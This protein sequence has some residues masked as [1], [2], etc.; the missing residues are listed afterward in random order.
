MVAFGKQGQQTVVGTHKAISLKLCAAQHIARD[1]AITCWLGII[2]HLWVIGVG[3][4]SGHEFFHAGSIFDAVIVWILDV[5]SGHGHCFFG[6][7]PSGAEHL[8]ECGHILWIH[9]PHHFAFVDGV[10][11]SDLCAYVACWMGTCEG[12]RGKVRGER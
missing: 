1:N 5:G 10:D 4:L 2:A 7:I 12:E 9:R 3:N 6:A 11:M 8:A